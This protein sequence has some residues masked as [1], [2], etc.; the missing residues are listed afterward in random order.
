MNVEHNKKTVM[1]FLDRFSAG[2][3]PGVLGLMDDTAKWKV[4][5]REGEPSTFPVRWIKTA[6]RS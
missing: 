6:L 4:M 3:V 5:G 1:E 2:D